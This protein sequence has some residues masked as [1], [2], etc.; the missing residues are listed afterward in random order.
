MLL[1]CPMR[2]KNVIVWIE[3]YVLYKEWLVSMR[4]IIMHRYPIRWHEKKL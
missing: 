4:I 2:L 3:L 1:L